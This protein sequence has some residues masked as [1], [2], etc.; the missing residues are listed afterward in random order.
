MHQTVDTAPQYIAAVMSQS[1][2]VIV[3]AAPRRPHSVRVTGGCAISGELRKQV[4]H[5]AQTGGSHHHPAQHAERQSE[6]RIQVRLRLQR[7]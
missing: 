2:E 3:W 1:E 5:A 6:T 4:S 7:A